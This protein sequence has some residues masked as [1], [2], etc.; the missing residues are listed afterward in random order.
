MTFLKN[1]YLK[2]IMEVF[3]RTK[4][5]AHFTVDAEYD[6]DTGVVH[7]ILYA[8]QWH[9][10][11]DAYLPSCAEWMNAR[12]TELRDKGIVVALEKRDEAP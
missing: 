12:L 10:I 6:T 4:P 1:P 5:P 9:S 11:P 2:D 7:F 8:D 3:G